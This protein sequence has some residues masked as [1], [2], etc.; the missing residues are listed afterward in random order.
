M[1]QIVTTVV[2]VLLTWIVASIVMGLGFGMTGFVESPYAALTAGVA[3][4]LIIVLV[5]VFT[6][7]QF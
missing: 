4:F 7:K 2:V 1:I 3:M 6:W 5:G